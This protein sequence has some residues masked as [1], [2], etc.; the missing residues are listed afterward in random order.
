MEEGG[1]DGE[2]IGLVG[3][4]ALDGF[5]EEAG[6]GG[7]CERVSIVLSDSDGRMRPR[8]SASW[9]SASV[10]KLVD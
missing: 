1:R 9:D 3:L 5:L 7:I 6:E 8:G 2:R 10:S 4:K